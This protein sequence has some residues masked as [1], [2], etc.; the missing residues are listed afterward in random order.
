[1]RY[2]LAIIAILPATDVADAKEPVARVAGSRGTIPFHKL[3]DRILFDVVAA[4]KIFGWK[5]ELTTPNKFGKFCRDV[6]CIPLRLTKAKTKTIERR[7]F[8]DAEAIGAALRFHITR[9]GG[10]ILV[11]PMK[12]KAD[13]EDLPAYNAA[14]GKGR[15]FRVGQT[16]PDIPLT[17]LNGNEVRFSKF[18]GKRY[19][20]YCW[21]SW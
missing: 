13:Q 3:D 12:S 4:A 21:A 15:G 11:T 20:I 2:L 5:W 19:I 17:D 10:E 8:V 1:M 14:W 7:L 6:G 16:V 18:L 9:R